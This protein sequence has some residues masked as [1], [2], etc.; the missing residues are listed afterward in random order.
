MPYENVSIERDG[1]VAVVTFDRRGSLNAFDQT[2]ILELTDMARS[3]Q[4]DLVTQAVVLTGTP[5]AFSAGIDLKDAATWEELDD[6]VALRDRFY[7]GVRLCQAWEDMP[8]IT[9]AAIEGL[10][11]GAGC[12]IALACDWRV[13]ARDAYLYVPEVKIGLNLQW[14]ALPRLV[15]LVGP[16][17]AKRIVLLCE[18]MGP[19]MALDWGLIDEIAE[20]GEAVAAARG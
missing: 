18:R 4:D 8:Q 13:L 5:N 16:A 9:V 10:A 20:G 14:G 6:D 17:R 11:V 1:N 19:E 15:T 7:R 12:A 3:F 2:T